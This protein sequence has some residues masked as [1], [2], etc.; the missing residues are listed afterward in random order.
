MRIL[1]S[2]NFCLCKSKKKF[3]NNKSDKKVLQMENAVCQAVFDGQVFRPTEK[4]SLSLDKKY[5]LRIQEIPLNENELNPIDVLDS[6]TGT[7]EGPE[8]W[9]INHDKYLYGMFENKDTNDV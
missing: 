1:L 2:E 6:L 4:I 9:A 5:L 7:V 8:D 3:E